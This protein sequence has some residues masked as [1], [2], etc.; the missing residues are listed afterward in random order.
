MFW[1]YQ[2]NCVIGRITL[3]V[4]RDL[5]RARARISINGGVLQINA[6]FS[7]E[8]EPWSTLPNSLFRMDTDVP[9]VRTGDEWG[10]RHD[11]TGIVSIQCKNDRSVRFETFIGLDAQLGWD[12][13]F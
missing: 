4:A 2:Y 13:V 10:I 8:G 12:Y 11:G 6:T 1:R 3:N 7:S 9:V 5:Q